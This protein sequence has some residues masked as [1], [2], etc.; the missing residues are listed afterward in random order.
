MALFP[1]LFT[2]HMSPFFWDKLQLFYLQERKFSRLHL[3]SWNLFALCFKV[4]GDAHHD[5]FASPDVI[6]E[7]Y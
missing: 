2:L 7:K 5:T 1:I 6:F 4:L 3:I